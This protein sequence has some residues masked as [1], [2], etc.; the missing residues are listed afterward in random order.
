MKMKKDQMKLAFPLN[1][2]LAATD[3]TIVRALQSYGNTPV[4]KILILAASVAS[5]AVSIHKDIYN[6]S[7]Q[8]SRSLRSLSIYA[9]PLSLLHI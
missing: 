2:I 7:L 9:M 4:I 3:A 1:M 8:C 5:V 6:R